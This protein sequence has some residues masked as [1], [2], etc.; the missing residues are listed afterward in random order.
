MWMDLNAGREEGGRTDST[1]TPYNGDEQ[2]S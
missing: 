2:Q 1:E